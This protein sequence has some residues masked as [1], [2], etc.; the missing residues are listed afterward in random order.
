[1]SGQNFPNDIAADQITS[2]TASKTS[3]VTKTSTS[4]VTQ[5]KTAT[6]TV[7]TTTSYVNR[8]KM[9]ITFTTTTTYLNYTKST[10]SS[11]TIATKTRYVSQTATTTVPTTIATTTGYVSQTATTTAPTT[12]AT[13]T[14]YVNQTATATAPT[15]VSTTT[16]YAPQTATATA[17]TTVAT[18]TSYVSQT[19]TAT[20]S[21]T[22]ST[23]TTTFVCCNT[24]TVTATSTTTTT[25][26][27]STS[28]STPTGLLVPLF[29]YP[30]TVSTWSSIASLPAAYP[31][32][33]VIAIINPDSGPGSSQDPNYVAGINSL[34]AA[35]VVT[36]GYVY[37]NYGAVSLQS[38]E[39]SIDA[40]KNLYGVTG[41]FL[42]AMAYHTGYESYYQ[43]IVSYAK[44]TDGMT[45]VIGNPG[46]DTVA[47]YVGNGGVDNIGFYEDFGTPTIAYLSS[48]FHT[49]YPK[50]Q[51]SFL[52]H[53]VATLNDSFIA[54]ASQYVSYLYISSGPGSAP[55]G[56][57]PSYLDQ[58]AADL[59]KV[60]PSTSAAPSTAPSNANGIKNYQQEALSVRILPNTRRLIF[61]IFTETVRQILSKISHD[62][63]LSKFRFNLNLQGTFR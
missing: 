25:S 35:G 62:T 63:Y 13:N 14:R 55:W 52:A 50:T 19:A 41:I 9:Q 37:T 1:M 22:L 36:I 26:T 10:T 4:L 32:V 59:A 16:S 27:A 53:G 60:N 51:W 3:T 5:S 17:P 18:T 42:D 45:F 44:G 58:M 47:S 34:K 11:N 28:P 48:P 49:T 46:T 38:V 33:P 57:F 23:T 39:S 7:S 24:Q 15:T 29:I 20:S 61:Q 43:S 12:I 40:W 8:T 2:T 31:N 30:V 54:Q 56:T 6:T 21:N